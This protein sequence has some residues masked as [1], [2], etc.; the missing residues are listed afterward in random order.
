MINV[1]KLLQTDIGLYGVWQVFH[2]FILTLTTCVLGKMTKCNNDS[3][4]L[5]R[6]IQFWSFLHFLH[7]L[8]CS[9]SSPFSAP[10]LF[11]LIFIHVSS[12][13]PFPAV[14]HWFLLL[15]SSN[16][17]LSLINLFF[18]H[19]TSVLTSFVSTLFSLLFFPTCYISWLLPHLSVSPS[20]SL[21][22]LLSLLLS[23]PLSLN[24]IPSGLSQAFLMASSRAA[25]RQQWLA[26]RTSRMLILRIWAVLLWED[27]YRTTVGTDSGEHACLCSFLIIKTPFRF[28]VI[29][30]GEEGCFPEGRRFICLTQRAFQ[31]D[32][33]N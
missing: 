28:R 32:V 24:D 30:A 33:L 23:F 5:I 11:F 15:S 3:S 26:E 18:S 19:P 6:V 13:F 8:S 25:G 12:P 1:H 20:P 17:P 10:P 31:Q 2:R 21:P 16:F 14:W 29:S 4:N 7:F 22:S 9:S 27:I